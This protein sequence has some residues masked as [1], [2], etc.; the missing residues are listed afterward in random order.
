[1]A[2]LL[3][4]GVR[5]MSIN[6]YCTSVIDN[7]TNKKKMLETVTLRLTDCNNAVTSIDLVGENI[8]ETLRM[9]TYSL[10]D[11]RSKCFSHDSVCLKVEALPSSILKEVMLETLCLQ[12]YRRNAQ[13]ES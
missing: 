11:E 8:I 7:N 5:Q 9:T 10:Y 6:S 12:T 3:F 4:S 1:M 2:Y 13:F